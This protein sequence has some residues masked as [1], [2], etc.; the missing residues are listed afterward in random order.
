MGKWKG[1]NI[2]KS[3]RHYRNKSMRKQKQV[4]QKWRSMRG[5][6]EQME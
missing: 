4:C 3:K 2:C 1:E 5:A 6:E